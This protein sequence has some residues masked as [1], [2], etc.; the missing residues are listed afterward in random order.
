[1]V[2]ANIFNKLAWN[3]VL[4]AKSFA[5]SGEAVANSFS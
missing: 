1:M 4:Q 2:L 5:F 3:A